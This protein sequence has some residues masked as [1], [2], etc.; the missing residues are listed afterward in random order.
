MNLRTSHR[1]LKKSLI[2]V[3][4][5]FQISLLKGTMIHQLLQEANNGFFAHRSMRL[6]FLKN[7][8]QVIPILAQ[9]LF[10]EWHTYDASVT[11]EKLI[12]SFKTRLNYDKVPMT[13]VAFKGETPIGVISLRTQTDPE[14]SDYPA[15]S[16]W[17]GSLFVVSEERNQGVGK[18][19]V[20]FAATI[21]KYLG[22]DELYFYTSAPTRVDWYLK[23]HAQILDKRTFHNHLVIVM[24]IPLKDLYELQCLNPCN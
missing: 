4:M 1:L 9:W 23:Q 17:M 20:K 2:V 11:Q 3:T 6:D 12:N 19:L 22:H 18:E 10:E 13:F 21:A 7:C 5:S 24:R 14:F 8:P 16:V 15:T